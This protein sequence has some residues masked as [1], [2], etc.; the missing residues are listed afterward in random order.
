[1]AGDGNGESSHRGGG[2][3]LWLL[4]G[5]RRRSAEPTT[6]VD[7]HAEQRQG[8]QA[9]QRAGQREVMAQAAELALHESPA[10]TR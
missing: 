2:T 7:G 10:R 1:M 3:R 4:N 9:V 6:G 5:R 8:V